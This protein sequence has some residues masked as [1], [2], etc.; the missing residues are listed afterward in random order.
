MIVDEAHLSRHLDSVADG[1][2]F[3]SVSFSLL[4]F[5]LLRPSS[6]PQLSI[7][8]SYLLMGFIAYTA[9][10]FFAARAWRLWRRRW[11]VILP[12][13]LLAHVALFSTC[14]WIFYSF[15]QPTWNSRTEG[16]ALGEVVQWWTRFKVVKTPLQLTA[17]WTSL[18]QSSACWG[19]SSADP[20]SMRRLVY[21][22]WTT[23]PRG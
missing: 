14:A 17:G 19:R 20:R 16:E 11:A 23:R 2:R 3:D 15:A 6:R 1:F 21:I 22:C 7:Y 18:G 12:V 8:S 10:L 5:A 9:Q 4:P 13:L